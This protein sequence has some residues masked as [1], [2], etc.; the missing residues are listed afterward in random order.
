MSTA[1]PL[2]SQMG[3][4][5]RYNSGV[6]NGR[7]RTRIISRC[8]CDGRSP[9][10]PELLKALTCGE[11][12]PSKAAPAQY[13]CTLRDDKTPAAQSLFMSSESGRPPVLAPLATG[14]RKP[15]ATLARRGGLGALDPSGPKSLFLMG[16]AYCRMLE[17]KKLHF[18]ASDQ[19]IS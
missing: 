18:D 2:R 11:V 1:S 8:M 17:P 14:V 6:P 10:A 16:M 12:L 7:P 5:A 13:S 9:L 19:Q 15:S 4:V 3:K